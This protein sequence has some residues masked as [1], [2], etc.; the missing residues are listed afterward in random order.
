MKRLTNFL[1]FT[2]LL[3]LTGCVNSG[4]NTKRLE[5]VSVEYH[6]NVLKWNKVDNAE[7][8]E[9]Y[10]NNVYYD[11]TSSLECDFSSFKDGEYTISIIACDEDII[12]SKSKHSSIKITVINSKQTIDVFMINDTHGAFLDGEYPGLSRISQ[13]LNINDPDKK[14]IKVANGDIFQGSYLSNSYYGL[15][16]I[17][18]FNELDFDCFVIGNHEFDWGLDKIAVYKDGNLNN[19]EAEFPF[20]GANI[21]DKRTNKMPE[22]IDPYTIVERNGIR[23]GIIGLIGEQQE[24][25]ILKEFVTDFEF[26]DAIPLIEKY[27]YELRNEKF[28]DIVILSIHDYDEKLNE[29][30]AKINDDS[31]IDL[32]LCGHTHTNNLQEFVRIDGKKILAVQNQDKN[33]TAS[34]VKMDVV[35][36]EYIKSSFE[37]IYLS[38]YNMDSAFNSLFEKYSQYE[39]DNNR[40]LGNTKNQISKDTLGYYAT[41]AMTEYFSVDYSVM[42]VA[43]IRSNIQI[44]DIMV[45]DVFNALPFNNE[46][47]IVELAGYEIKSL[48]NKNSEF[49]YFDK[50]FDI[51]KIINNE[52]YSIAVIDYVFT[53]VYYTEFKNKEYYDSDTILRDLLIQYI[54]DK[55]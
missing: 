25:S 27:A 8:Y 34:H 39:E 29:K 7:S 22:W 43:G 17:E 52:T 45:S 47:F 35:N 14:F 51:N 6:N 20:L 54:D 42:N 33:K 9:I 12:Y 40:L 28:C 36:K 15:P 50:D 4:N 44:G 46:V 30:V 37:R 13:F 24:S 26:L 5:Q 18:A 31:L 23:V 38:N 16:F 53:G 41:S 19:G 2:F 21:I 10:V 49:L 48:Y 3:F 11:L 32:I 1:L 55:Y